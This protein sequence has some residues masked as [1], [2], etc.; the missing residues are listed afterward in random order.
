MTD[1]PQL[2]FGCSADAEAEGVGKEIGA[3]ANSDC[4]IK[5]KDKQLGS[6]EI[7]KIP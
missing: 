3:E 4:E 2:V 6:T 7:L 1:V 5:Q